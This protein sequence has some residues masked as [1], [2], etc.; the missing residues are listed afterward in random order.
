M[1]SGDTSLALSTRDL[2]VGYDAT[3][4]VDHIE[5]S[6]PRGE[7]LA[8]VGTNGS[9]KSTLLKTIVGLQAPLGGQIEV[10]GGA[11]GAR[12]QSVAYLGQF[13]AARFV[14]P[15][16]ALD[17]VRMGRFASLGLFRRFRANDHRLVHEAM[18]HFDVTAF[19]GQPLRSLSGGQQQRVHLAQLMARDA[20]LLVL[21]EPT[22]GLDLSGRDRYRQFF[23]DALDRGVS[24]ITATHDIAEAA[25]CHQAI[26]L[27]RR[28]VAQ[29]PSAQVLTA[30]NLLTTFGIALAGLDHAGHQ[31]LLLS[32]EPHAHSHD[33]GHGQG[34]P[35]APRGPG[36][37]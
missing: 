25:S 9:G 20:D 31:D 18:E 21:D 28:V 23:D 2:S 13:H 1:S 11:P 27:A 33:D 35:P 30:D 15:L 19:A 7:A 34:Y 32:E 37:S 3:P 24:V 12:P 16:Q 6:L 36:R 8:L 14:L 4:V 17:V 10:L 29:G 26:L 5:I 22:V